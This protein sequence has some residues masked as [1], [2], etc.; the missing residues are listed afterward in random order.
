LKGAPVDHILVR[1]FDLAILAPA[2][3]KA[4][5]PAHQLLKRNKPFAMFLPADLLEMVPKRADGVVD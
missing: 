4:P 1:Y 2:T 5:L 3:L